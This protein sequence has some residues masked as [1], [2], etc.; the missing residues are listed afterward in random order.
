MVEAV[1]RFRS[2]ALVQQHTRPK[3]ARKHQTRI[4]TRV[5]LQEIFV[6][7]RGSLIATRRMSLLTGEDEDGAQVDHDD[8]EVADAGDQRSRLPCHADRIGRG[9]TQPGERR[10]RT[11]DGGATAC[12]LGLVRM[13][14][15]SLIEK[16]FRCVEVAAL[17]QA[18]RLEA[19]RVAHERS[20]SVCHLARHLEHRF[21]GRSRGIGSANEI[22]RMQDFWLL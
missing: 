9:A 16:L 13:L 1:D 22:S 14:E 8:A 19:Q 6:Q 17:D 10:A 2:A 5:E 3:H 21:A 18:L 20:R 15:P 11:K 4:G 12:L 7:S